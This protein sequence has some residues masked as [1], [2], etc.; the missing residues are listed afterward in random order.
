MTTHHVPVRSARDRLIDLLGIG[1]AYPLTDLNV[2]AD[3]LK[4]PFGGTARIPIEHAQEGVTYELCD[5]KGQPLGNA[6]RADGH[7]AT[8]VIDTPR[9]M[10]NVT[11]RIRATKRSSGPAWPPQAPRF[12]DEPAP[13]EV[14]LDTGL[15]IEIVDVWMPGV[16]VPAQAPLLDPANAHPRPSDPRIVPFGASVDVRI[17]NSQEGVQYSLILDGEEVKDPVRTGD[18]AAILLRTRPMHEDAVIQVRATKTFLAAENRGAETKPLDAAL[19]L[20]VKANPAVAVSV[21]ASPIVGYREDATIRIA[22]TQRSAEYRAY[23]RAIVDRDFVHGAT[24][25]GNIVIVPVAGKPVVQVRMPTPSDVWRTPD[26]YTALGGGS[27]PGTGEDLTFTVKTLADDTTIILQ[28]TKN[29]QVDASNR[30]STSIP[31]AIRVDQVAVVLVRPDPARILTLRV[32]MIGATTGGT[33]Q[34][35]DGQPGVFYYF[36]PAPAGAEFPLPAYFH[37]RDDQ[38]T[39]RNKGVGQLGL[40]IDFAVAR[41]P[42]APARGPTDPASLFPRSPLL[43]IT[44]VA[45]DSSLASRAVKAQTGVEVQMARAAEVMAVPDIRAEQAVVDYGAAATILIP[46]SKPEDQ[47]QVMLAGA[48]VTSALTGNAADL[49]TITGR[50][51]EDATFEVVVTRP[52]GQGMRVERVAPV[53][54]RVRP[55]TAL[56]VA[57]KS[58]TVSKGSSTEVVVDGTQEGVN[59]Q[60][61]AEQ[62]TLGSAVPGNGASIALPTG[63]IS[64]DTTFTVA[65]VR[66]DDARI[67]VALTARATVTLEAGQ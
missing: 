42:D 15:V 58:Q 9:V 13:V 57:A 21:D 55:N 38:D 19:H 50:L 35:S 14:G 25:D 32:P 64:V 4:V 61:M 39:S 52:A 60:L 2:V 48:N 29:H 33:M 51:V 11:Y 28:A 45:A 8:L 30:A 16:A 10:E 34:V 66:A 22:G 63:P 26:G 65:A 43:S 59:Y 46:A 27:A 67:S 6:F 62:A 41:G 36:R 56:P 7:D 44:A 53:P 20:K 37:K 54:V 17:N 49:V 12:L 24:T 23:G 3:Q 5:P 1:D 47:Y 18:L 40:E 31:S